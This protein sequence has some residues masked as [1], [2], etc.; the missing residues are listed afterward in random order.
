LREA[1]VGSADRREPSLEPRLLTQPRHGVGRVVD[2]AH[3]GLEDAT[4]TERPAATGQDHVV[5]AGCEGNTGQGRADEIEPVRPAD[6]HRPRGLPHRRVMVGQQ[7][8]TVTHPDP[9]VAGHGLIRRRRRQ[10]EPQADHCV[11]DSLQS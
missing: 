6:Q 8:H 3:H 11:E 5:A 4:G 1:Q 2:L 10:P 7:L 9:Q